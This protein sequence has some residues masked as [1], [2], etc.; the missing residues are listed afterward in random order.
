MDM[1][2]DRAFDVAPGAVQELSPLVRRV[3]CGN[4][5]PFTFKGTSTYIVGKGQVAIIDPGPADNDHLRALLAAVAGETVS[6]ILVSH[7]HADHS[8]LAAKLKAATGATTFAFGGITPGSD[9]GLRLDASI[10][11]D[12]VP[13]V[14]LPDGA[15]IDGPGWTLDAIFTPGH[16]SN[17][18]C[19]AL[20]EEHTLFSGDHVMAW[21]TSVVAPPDGHM[22]D[23]MASLRKLVGRDDRLYL[24]GH[25]PGKAD[26]QGLLR[27]YIS[28][29]RM[30]E[31]AILT[32]VKEGDRTLEAIVRAVYAGLDPK[33]FGA[34]GLSTRAHLDHL[35]EQDRVRESEGVYEAM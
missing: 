12:F 11:H 22:C 26:P 16:M 21:A 23:Y 25:G 5:S 10:D 30:R 34:A 14:A 27:G 13:G 3:L 1:E 18:M 6:H 9:D 20:R 31:A 29:R 15:V 7:S 33:L 8:P 2:F 4:P 17:H 28:H 24:P 35:I 19:F 32:R